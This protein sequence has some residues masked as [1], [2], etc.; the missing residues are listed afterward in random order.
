MTMKYSATEQAPVA[1]D[2]IKKA[3]NLTKARRDEGPFVPHSARFVS[4]A[5]FFN[6][7][8]GN[9]LA[10]NMCLKYYKLDITLR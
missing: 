10:L 8:C 2:S 1:R 9:E 3:G 4:F 7:S 6:I 5:S